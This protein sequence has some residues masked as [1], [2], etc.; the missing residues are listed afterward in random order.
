MKIHILAISG[1]MTAPLAI[2]LKNQGHI[3]TGSD[4]D[5]IYPPFSTQLSQAKIP[6][7][8]DSINPDLYIIGSGFA[9]QTKLKSEFEVIKKSK[10]PY[11]SATEY[12][13]K[14]L[15]KANSILVAGSFGKS[16]ITAMLV[17]LLKDTKYNPSY[18]FGAN[19]INKFSSLS[20]TNSNWSVCEADESING[21]DTKAKFLYYPVKYLILTSATWEHKESYKTKKD[22]LSAYKNLIL[23]IPNDGLLVYN[24][25]ELSIK[26]LLKFAKCKVI[27]YN[28]AS[29]K[30]PLLFGKA[31]ENN[32]AA[33]KALCDYLK[34]KIENISK[35]KGLK[36]RL[37]LTA[38]KKN[39]LFYT[40]FAQSAPRISATISALK[41][42][43]K[44]RKIYVILNPRAGFLQYKKSILELTNSFNSVTHIYLTKLSFTKNLS[45]SA[46]VSFTDYKSVFGG[47]ISYLP[48]SN[49]L[50]NTVTK[51]LKSGDILIQ[52]SSGSLDGYRDFQKII[53]SYT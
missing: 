9:N 47:K 50:I 3:V 45:K 11:I 42:Q 38:N 1:K 31:F 5:K 20:F 36:N 29:I 48:M 18:M 22:N 35:F 43:Y 32:F 21:L 52:F 26:P 28:T 10:I 12:I 15:I 44:N 27:S 39:I 40:D 30:H 37:E 24:S 46:R 8:P 4:Q 7:N 33:V 17:F 2:A 14:N 25:N 34:V 23:N 19:P 53:K 51:S 13:A 49:D 41:T 16:T 6:I